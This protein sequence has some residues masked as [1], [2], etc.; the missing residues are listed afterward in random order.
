M[1]YRLHKAAPAAVMLIVGVLGC[2][3][4]SLSAQPLIR[5]ESQLQQSRNSCALAA[6]SYALSAAYHVAATEQ[7]L[8]QLAA[9]FYASTHGLPP[10]EGYSIGDI[11]RLSAK[12]G[13]TAEAWRLPLHAIRDEVLPALLWLK[14]AGQNHVV[15]LIELLPN[16]AYLFDPAVGHYW[17]S[18]SR[19]S[20]R[21]LDGRGRGVLIELRNLSKRPLE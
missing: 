7:D 18:R 13:V 21:W 9:P 1:R 17:L 8:A 6:L 15:V 19:L 20:D 10:S 16:A 2:C 5:I 11:R 4:A 14:E 12:L 3:P